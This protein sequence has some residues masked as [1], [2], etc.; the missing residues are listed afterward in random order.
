M[1]QFPVRDC[2]QFY[3][4]LCHL[5]YILHR[6]QFMQF[7]EYYREKV[8]KNDENQ[9]EQNNNENNQ[10]DMN[11]SGFLDQQGRPNDNQKDRLMQDTY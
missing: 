4:K 3:I 10:Q 11:N 8:G 9:I 1:L 5:E 6:R 7:F 2:K